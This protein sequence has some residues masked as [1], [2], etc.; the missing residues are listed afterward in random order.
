MM[1]SHDIFTRFHIPEPPPS[2]EQQ[3]AIDRGEILTRDDLKRFRNEY[4]QPIQLR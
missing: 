1:Y 2:P 3:A 4:A